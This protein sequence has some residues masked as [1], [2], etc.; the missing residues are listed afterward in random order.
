MAMMSS[1]LKLITRHTINSTVMLQTGGKAASKLRN[2]FGIN[3]TAKQVNAPND[4][5][6]TPP[7]AF[8]NQTGPSYFD[9]WII[10][11]FDSTNPHHKSI[12]T[13]FYRIMLILM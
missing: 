7:W 3:V 10:I 8:D 9:V 2:L 1:I 5:S 13:K 11:G 6:Q 12:Y 4:T